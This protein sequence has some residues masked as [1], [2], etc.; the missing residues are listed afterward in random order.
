MLLYI[1]LLLLQ[2]GSE[3]STSLEGRESSADGPLYYVVLIGSSI[4]VAVV[5][6]LFIKYLF[7]PQEDSKQHIKR[8]I[9]KEDF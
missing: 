2:K 3:F 1:C 8:R 6:V 9:L 4:V 5:F 7:W